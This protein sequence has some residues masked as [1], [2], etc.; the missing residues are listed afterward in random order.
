MEY[1][2]DIP[3][4]FGFLILISYPHTSFPQLMHIGSRVP[5]FLRKI[6]PADMLTIEEES[7]SAFPYYT[8]TT[9]K[10]LWLKDRWIFT[11]ETV[12]KE[13]ANFLDNVFLFSF[14][15]SPEFF[16]L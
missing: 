5:G 6:L 13:G 9:E 4:V 7:W 3:S 15:F 16:L 10:N 2:V 8:K 11:M 1:T 12:Y 14:S